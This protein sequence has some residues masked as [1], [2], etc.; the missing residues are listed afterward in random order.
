[1][2]FGELAPYSNMYSRHDGSTRP[3]QI[4]GTKPVHVDSVILNAAARYS[5]QPRSHMAAREVRLQMS[6]EGN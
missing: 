5:W 4:A 3:I 2:T 6:A 1:M